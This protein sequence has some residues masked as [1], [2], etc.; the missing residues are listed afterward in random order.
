MRGYHNFTARKTG[1]RV[2]SDWVMMWKFKDGRVTHFQ[3]FTDTAALLDAVTRS[4]GA[5]A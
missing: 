4:S 1:R 5:S 3:E 2:G